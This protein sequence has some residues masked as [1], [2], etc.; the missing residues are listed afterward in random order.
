MWTLVVNHANVAD[1]VITPAEHYLMK[2][3]H[4]GVM[5]NARVIKNAVADES[6]PAPG[7]VREWRKGEPL[8]MIWHSRVSGE[9][10]IMALLEALRKVEGEYILDVYGGGPELVK[11]KLYAQTYHLRQVKFHGDTKFE[12][13]KEK[14]G[15]AHLDMLVSYNYD[16][17]PMTLLEAQAMGTPVFIC[18]RDM[19]SLVPDGG[20]E[21][22]AGPTAEEIA[23]A[24]NKL[25]SHRERIREM[26]RVM[27][28]HREEAL[29]SGRI[30]ELVKTFEEIRKA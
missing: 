14:L 30:N 3:K 19:A 13:L 12:E 23:A 20:Y 15:E 18:D 10:R 7:K 29:Q 16:V 24:L 4:Y 28:D 5:R 9:K 27:T 2:L 21:L 26:S 1:Y 11:A 25:Y 6:F 8:R 22:A 17:C